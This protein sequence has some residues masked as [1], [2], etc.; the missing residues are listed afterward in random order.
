VVWYHSLREANLV[1]V[2][3][4][5]DDMFEDWWLTARARFRDKEQKCFD[6]LEISTILINNVSAMQLVS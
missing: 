4:T 3:P 2:T 5:N 6:I 1:D